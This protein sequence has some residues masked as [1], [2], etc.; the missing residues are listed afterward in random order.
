MQML[1][2]ADSP[3]VASQRISEFVAIRHRTIITVLLMIAD[4]LDHLR[5]HVRIDVVLG[6]P[7]TDRINSLLSNGFIELNVVQFCPR[8]NCTN[9]KPLYTRRKRADKL[10]ASERIDIVSA[11]VNQ[12]RK[13]IR[14]A[15]HN[16]QKGKPAGLTAKR[17]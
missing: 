15:V 14:G 6:E 4:C 5:S 11:P 16:I 3:Q 7:L 10:Q 8:R 13:L 2:M 17:G 1:I 12:E 9:T